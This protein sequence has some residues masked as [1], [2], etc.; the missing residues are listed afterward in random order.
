M[1][2]LSGDAMNSDMVAKRKFSGALAGSAA[3]S[4]GLSSPKG[5]NS[6]I[7]FESMP[8]F[9][10]NTAK[11]I[12]DKSLIRTENTSRNRMDSLMRMPTHK[13]GTTKFDA[14]ND[15]RSIAPLT[16]ED[17]GQF[18]NLSLMSTLRSKQPSQMGQNRNKSVA[19][20]NPPSFYEDDLKK[21]HEK[22]SKAIKE[23]QQFKRMYFSGERRTI[24]AGNDNFVEQDPD[25]RL[26]EAKYTGGQI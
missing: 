10:V 20:E 23:R 18:H 25:K 13:S 6:P 8:A 15:V 22:F 1:Q 9:T 14:N 16:S 17:I 21:K 19:I 5:L 26:A 2:K 11:G 3:M 24:L 4:L 7:N 12:P